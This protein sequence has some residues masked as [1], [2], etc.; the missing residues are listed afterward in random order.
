MFGVFSILFQVF[1][2]SAWDAPLQPGEQEI[3]LPNKKYKGSSKLPAPSVAPVATSLPG[4]PAPQV[5]PVK[6]FTATFLKKAASKSK[7]ATPKKAVSKLGQEAEKCAS[8]PKKKRINFALTKNKSQELVDHLRG[9]KS[10]PQTPHDPSKN[11]AKSLLKP[12]RRS[13]EADQTKLNPLFLNT[14]L[15][16][17]SKT[18]KLLKR[19]STAM[20]FF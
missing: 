1:E 13:L 5:T 14:Q 18:A 2:E 10:S 4:F 16:S 19:R 6:S 8:E 20:D 15:N 12:G 7:S 3:V 9:V 11:P 17:R